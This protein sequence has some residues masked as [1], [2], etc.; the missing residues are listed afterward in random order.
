MESDRVTGRALS[1]RCLGSRFEEF[2]KVV[3]GV[4][5]TCTVVLGRDKESGQSV[6]I[7]AVAKAKLHCQAELDQERGEEII[8]R[9]AYLV[10]LIH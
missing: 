9:I 10:D 8:D 5:F 7:K 6:A 1:G 2:G 4:G 3:Y